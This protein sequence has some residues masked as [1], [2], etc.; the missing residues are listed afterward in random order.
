MLTITLAERY[1]EADR[2]DSDIR[3]FE[4]FITV[5]V[6]P[7]KKHF[8]IHQDAICG[9]SKFFKAACSKRWLEGQEK[10]VH[11]LD[12]EVEVFREYCRWVYS[13]TMP[14]SHCSR[15]SK[16]KEITA[17]Q[18]L[19]INPYLLGDLLDDFQ[20]RR[21]AT[22]TF[23]RC[24]KTT[25][26]LLGPRSLAVVWSSTPPGSLFREQLV[27]CT[28]GSADRAVLAERIADVPPE[29]VQEVAI[30]ALRRSTTT[31]L[32]RVMSDGSQYLE[33]EKLELPRD[34]TV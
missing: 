13:G 32:E 6:G 1:S 15:E 21:V 9:K 17:E 19:L 5:L 18:G 26:G 24:L 11:L 14:I 31:R 33:P 3:D 20:L 28:V 23:Y 16:V 2:I 25:G 27:D 29:F 22:K 8:T 30:A 34:N 4:S 7:D 10:L 12:V